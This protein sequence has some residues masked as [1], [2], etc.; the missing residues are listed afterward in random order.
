MTLAARVMDLATTHRVDAI[1]VD[2]GGV[3]GGVIDRLRMLRQPVIEVQFGARSDRA[4][5]NQDGNYI[6]ANKRS[7]IWGALREWLEGGMIDNDPELVAELNAMQ[8]GY[9]LRDGRDAIMLER[10]EDMKR[11]G[12]ASPDNADALALTF[13]Y[14]V[15]V[16]DHSFALRKKPTHQI[17]YN[18]FAEAQNIVRARTG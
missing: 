8:Y 17:D 6:Y 13:A 5:F 12:L 1:F 10:K 2:G 18:P 11:R 14:P 7:E 16:S 4:T 3:G 9:V 15:Q